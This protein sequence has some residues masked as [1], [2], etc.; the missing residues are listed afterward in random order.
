[1]SLH[2]ESHYILLTWHK[3]V[4]HILCFTYLCPV[5]MAGHE[6]LNNIL[7][8]YYKFKKSYGQVGIIAGSLMIML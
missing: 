4:K 6:I 3:Y 8:Q 1:M 7:N 5:L 2:F